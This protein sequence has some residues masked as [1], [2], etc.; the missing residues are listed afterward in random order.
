MIG[1]FNEITGMSEKEGGSTR[2]RQQMM[3][4]L[5]TINCC[6]LRDISFVGLKYTWWYVRRDGEQ[7]KERL[8]RALVT[9]E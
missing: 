8:D 2:P 3:N 5:N 9:T 1:D 6:R 4:F 7:I